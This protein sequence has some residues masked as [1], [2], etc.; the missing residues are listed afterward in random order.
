MNMP[1]DFNYE[2]DMKAR[3]G[4]AQQGPS[5]RQI[6]LVGKVQRESDG[7]VM[8]GKARLPRRHLPLVKFRGLEIKMA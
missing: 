6:S 4:N 7:S 8:I 5:L 2:G 3:G 1:R